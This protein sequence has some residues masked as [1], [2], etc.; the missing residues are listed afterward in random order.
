MPTSIDQILARL[1]EI[2]AE[3]GPPFVMD[4]LP[5][6]GAI[7]RRLRDY[8]PE[9]E[10]LCEELAASTIDLSPPTPEEE[11]WVAAVAARLAKN[12]ERPSA[13]GRSHI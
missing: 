5:D 11:A 1:A 2:C 6:G 4:P 8:T 9:E 10:R 13:E 3:I 7:E 12:K